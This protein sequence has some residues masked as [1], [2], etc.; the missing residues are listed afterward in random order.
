MNKPPEIIALDPFGSG[1]QAVGAYH[2]P[3][4]PENMLMVLG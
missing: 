1:G 2:H 3:I 4:D